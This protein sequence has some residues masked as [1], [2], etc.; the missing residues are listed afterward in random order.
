MKFLALYLSSMMI[1]CMGYV[2]TELIPNENIRNISS[3]VMVGIIL[4]VA[5]AWC[6][7]GIVW[8]LTS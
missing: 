7:P 1:T 2:L 8:L 6:V 3:S 5:V 4:T